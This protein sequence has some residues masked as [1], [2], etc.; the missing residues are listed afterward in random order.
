VAVNIPSGLS[1]AYENLRDAIVPTVGANGTNLIVKCVWPDLLQDTAFLKTGFRGLVDKE[2]LTSMILQ[3]KQEII[4]RKRD[5]N[6]NA[7]CKMGSVCTIPLKGQ[8]EVRP[9][10][11][12]IL[13]DP[14][15]STVLY[16]ILR[17]HTRENY[18]ENTLMTVQQ[19]TKKY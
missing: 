3:V 11:V 7:D 12:H 1:N 15:G 8:F 16:V 17:A 9:V 18:E 4:T 6:I 10:Q 13:Q 5:S 2:S 14:H 19:V